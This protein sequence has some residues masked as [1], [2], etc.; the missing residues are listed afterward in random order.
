MIRKYKIYDRLNKII[1]INEKMVQVHI[2]TKCEVRI[3]RK[4]MS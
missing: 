1:I 2:H 4:K 3:Y